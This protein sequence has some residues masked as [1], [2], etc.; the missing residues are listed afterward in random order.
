MHGEVFQRNKSR[1]NEFCRA[2]LRSKNVIMLPI[3]R[4]S[5]TDEVAVF[6]RLFG[7]ERNSFMIAQSEAAAVE[8]KPDESQQVQP[9]TC[10][11]TPA[12]SVT[13]PAAGHQF[14]LLSNVSASALP[15]ATTDVQNSN[16]V[17]VSGQPQLHFVRMMNGEA[18]LIPVVGGYNEITGVTTFAPVSTIADAATVIPLVR[19][20][21]LQPVASIMPASTNF[22]PATFATV[23]NAPLD[24][25]TRA[26]QAPAQP[27][28][29]PV[30][31]QQQH[32]HSFSYH[33]YARPP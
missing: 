8:A 9:Q 18:I 22:A 19:V 27:P 2:V 10:A 17:L 15:L 13:M 30:L 11:A 26:T 12:S 14:H 29:M 7:K 32:Q 5:D 23:L 20:D 31:L 33:P 21:H 16:H 6:T 1:M 24:L 4:P 3:C 28:S 25:S